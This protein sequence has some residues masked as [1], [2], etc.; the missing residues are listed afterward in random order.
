MSKDGFK[1]ANSLEQGSN[2]WLK[3]RQLGIGASEVAIILGLSPWQTKFQLWMSKT[4]LGFQPAPNQFALRAMIRGNI[5]EPFGRKLFEKKMGCKFDPINLVDP[6]MPF[7]KASLDGYNAE[8]KAI[9][10]LKAPGKTGLAD[11][12]KGK[13]PKYYYPQIQQ[14]L[15]LAKA[16][17]CYY[18]VFDGESEIIVQEVRPDAEYQKMLIEEIK[19]FWKLVEDKTPPKLSVKDLDMVN[20]QIITQLAEL[21]K[22]TQALSVLTEA[23]LSSN[24]GGEEE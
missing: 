10:E 8:T 6:D 17:V 16:D 7:I 13:I 3:D 9:L 2:Q 20:K 5:T 21:Q 23:M 22:A 19:K 18:V 4:G 12:R 24:V 15:Y 1:K 14:Q 11:A